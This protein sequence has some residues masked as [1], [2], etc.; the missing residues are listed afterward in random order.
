MIV[1]V[2]A[3]NAVTSPAFDTVATVVFEETHG[4]VDAGE[5]DPTN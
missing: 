2:P 3:V 1:V 5:A 4:F